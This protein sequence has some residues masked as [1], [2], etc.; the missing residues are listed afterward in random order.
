MSRWSSKGPEWEKLRQLQFANYG[1]QCI[2]MY[3]AI[4]EGDKHLTLDH[5]VPKSMGGEDTIENTQ[6]LCNKCNSKKRAG[7][8]IVDKAWFNPHYFKDIPRPRS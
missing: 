3:P 7:P 8:G 2:G 4:C 6:V 5:I 1:Y